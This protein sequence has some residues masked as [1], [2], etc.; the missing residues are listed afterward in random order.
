MVT[1]D[2]VCGSSFKKYSLLNKVIQQHSSYRNPHWVSDLP[3]HF[4][5]PKTLCGAQYNE[6]VLLFPVLNPATLHHF[7]TVCHTGRAVLHSMGTESIQ[8]YFSGFSTFKR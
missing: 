8:I 5:L 6:N 7:T 4:A 2:S 3:V 1:N